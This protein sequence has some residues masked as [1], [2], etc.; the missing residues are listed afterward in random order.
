LSTTRNYTEI[1]GNLGGSYQIA[2]NT[3]KPF[4]CGIVIHPT[5]DACIQLRNQHTLAA[6]DIARIDLGVHPLVL[7]LTG[8]RTPQTGLE[9]K[10]SVYF[11]AALAVVR[12]S[13]GMRD[14]SDEN[15]RDPVIVA[16]RD[17]VVATIDPAVKEDQVQARVTLNDGRVL[18][19]FVEHAVGSLER[20]MSNAELEAKALGLMAGILPDAQARALVDL[21]WKVD[22]LPG[23][24]ALAVAAVPPGRM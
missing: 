24:A 23:A 6:A 11:A 19:R 9:A 18:S 1:T 13:A 2:L 21:C 12:G 20:P 17:R 5:I 8:K 4:A 14:F 22:S 3:Y 15:T 7:E 16:L 10:F